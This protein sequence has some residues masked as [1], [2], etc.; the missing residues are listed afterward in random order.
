MKKKTYRFEE[1]SLKLPNLYHLDACRQGGNI[2]RNKKKYTRKG[3][4]RFDYRKEYQEE[5]EME[6]K[7]YVVEAV[8]GLIGT[9]V[10]ALALYFAMRYIDVKYFDMKLDD[11]QAEVYQELQAM[12]NTL[13]F[14]LPQTKW[15]QLIENKIVL[16]LFVYGGPVLIG[17]IAAIGVVVVLSGL[18]GSI[19]NV[20]TNYVNN[21][22]EELQRQEEEYR[23]YSHYH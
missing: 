23:W 12:S 11:S 2:Y 20:A 5:E 9:M 18:G 17:A 16:T 15:L 8:I 14:F 6:K 19:T 3:K 10:V 22:A 13:F 1:R 21:Q 7:D 4:S